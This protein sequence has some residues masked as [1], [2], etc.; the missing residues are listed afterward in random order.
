MARLLQ[1][2]STL[3]ITLL[4]A[5]HESDRTFL[6]RLNLRITASQT[7]PPFEPG[8]QVIL[9]V[10]LSLF[11]HKIMSYGKVITSPPTGDERDT[12]ELMTRA[13]QDRDFAF[14]GHGGFFHLGSSG[15]SSKQIVSPIKRA[16]YGG[17]GVQRNNWLKTVLLAHH[18]PPVLPVI[19]RRLSRGPASNQ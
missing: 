6:I 15:A 18:P 8:T 13:V 2:S 1:N 14:E 16:G 12:K 10:Q 7:L 11:S 5:Q 4:T 19:E 17:G 3:R 9:E